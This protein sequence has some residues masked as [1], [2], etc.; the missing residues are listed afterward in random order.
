MTDKEA[1]LQSME[2]FNYDFDAMAG[3]NGWLSPEDA[4]KL[5]ARCESAESDLLALKD[6]ITAS[7]AEAKAKLEV[8]EAQL[9]TARAVMAEECARFW[10]TAKAS[11]Q[12][13]LGTH[14][15]A[16]APLPAT[17]V[18]VERRHAEEIARFL[19]H[20]HLSHEI[21]EAHAVL[22]NLLERP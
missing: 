16:L 11:E 10:Q 3:A 20:M 4:K 1:L 12:A 6:Y 18:A 22:S 7:E 9:A 15:R 19:G 21:R 5:E 14:L 13:V 17:L 2:A 8:A